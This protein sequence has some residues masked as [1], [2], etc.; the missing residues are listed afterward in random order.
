M[1]C[2]SCGKELPIDALH[3]PACGTA[4]SGTPKSSPSGPG[5]MDKV[6]AASTDSLNAFKSFALNPVGE[7]ANVFNS[8]GE[9]RSLGVGITFGVVSAL[10]FV[11]TAYLM[12]HKMLSP[13][14][15][16]YLKLFIYA[17]IPA[18]TTAA[19]SFVARKI[20]KS[21]GGIGVD[22]F[23]AGAAMLPFSFATLLISILMSA[24]DPDSLHRLPAHRETFGALLHPGCSPGDHRERLADADALQPTDQLRFRRWR[25]RS[26]L[27]CATSGHELN[28][29]L[30]QNN[31]R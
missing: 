2:A 7:L 8:L 4:K 19:A 18:I 20:L 22:A 30:V 15:G 31:S 10:C 26:R 24:P 11:L 1:L 13:S 25:G 3:C 12:L 16:W 28:T 29:S 27:G 6:K 21:E 17:F 14:A 5:V 9:S 23:I